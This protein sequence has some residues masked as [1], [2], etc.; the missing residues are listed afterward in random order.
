M[1]G[2]AETG[3]RS[4]RCRGRR[5]YAPEPAPGQHRQ[6]RRFGPRRGGTDSGTPAMGRGANGLRV[7]HQ[8]TRL[9]NRR[10]CRNEYRCCRV[11][12]SAPERGQSLSSSRQ[13]NL[14]GAG[15]GS[16]PLFLSER[17]PTFSLCCC[18]PLACRRT[19]PPS[20][21]DWC[22]S[23]LPGAVPPSDF[24]AEFRHLLLDLLLLQPQADKGGFQSFAVQSCAC[25]QR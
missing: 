20:S 9:L 10:D 19:H 24:A 4:C 15:L 6:R 12:P 23:S 17:R 3:G 18:N 14:G 13:A 11:V 25:H 16:L 2:E 5:R 22:R 8:P 7:P 21:A 1:W